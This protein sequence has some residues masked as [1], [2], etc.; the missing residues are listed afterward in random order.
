MFQ[1]IISKDLVVS[2]LSPI[3]GNPIPRLE[4][5]KSMR[6]IRQINIMAHKK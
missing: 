6:L 5:V 2:I 1:V 4:Q 3:D